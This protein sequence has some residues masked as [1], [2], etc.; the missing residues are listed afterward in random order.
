MNIWERSRRMIITASIT[1]LEFDTDNDV[2]QIHFED[3]DQEITGFI[4][5]PLHVFSFSEADT[6]TIEVEIRPADVEI[7]DKDKKRLKVAYNAIFY[8]LTRTGD[9]TTRHLSAG[10]YLVRLASKKA[11]DI[12]AGDEREFKILVRTSE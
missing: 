12:A 10:G 9:V 3:R 5:I 2:E 8:Q 11:L 7:D 1:K 6:S 4:E